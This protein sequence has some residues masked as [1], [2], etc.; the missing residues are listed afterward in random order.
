[1]LYHSSIDLLLRFWIND[2]E[3]L[4]LLDLNWRYLTLSKALFLDLMWGYLRLILSLE[5]FL[6][7]LL[8]FLRLFLLHLEVL[9]TFSLPRGILY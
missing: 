4:L 5:V 6:I 8:L 3:F 1:M 7:P 9:F 2:L